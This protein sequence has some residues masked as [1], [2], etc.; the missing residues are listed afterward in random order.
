MSNDYPNKRLRKG[1]EGG[2]VY[3]A[4]DTGE[5]L[6]ITEEYA[7]LDMLDEEDRKG[8]SPVTVRRFPSPE[9]RDQYLASRNW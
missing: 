7:M 1:F 3:L 6:I 9:E 8:L 4:E 2:A 5:W